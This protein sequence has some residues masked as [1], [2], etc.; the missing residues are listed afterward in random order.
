[1]NRNIFIGASAVVIILVVGYFVLNQKPKEA[2]GAPIT[3]GVATLLT[4]DFAVLGE[5]IVQTARLAADEVNKNGGINGRPLELVIEDSKLDSRSGVAAMQKLV[6]ADGIRYIIGGMSS[7]GSVAAAPI[8]NA[9]HAVDLTPVTG[10][11]NVDEAGDYIFRIANSDVLAGRDLANAML[12]MGYKNVGVVGAVTEYTIDIQK[13]FEKTITD[14]GGTIVVSEQFQPGTTDYRT[15]IAKVRAKNP[16]AVLVLS[17]LGTD[18]AYFVKQ[19]REVGYN[20][21]LFTDF[22]FATNGNVKQIL[23]SLDGIYFTDPAYDANNAKTKAFFALY[24]ATYKTDPAIP[25]HAASTYD[26]VMMLAEALR[27]EG[28]D[29]AKVQQYLSTNIKNYHGLMG[30]YSLDAQGNS[31][32]GFTVRVIKNGVPTDIQ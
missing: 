12:K 2:N 20:P 16:Q 30:T 26:G 13:T 31:D 8:A 14:Q 5:N 17:Q 10:G 11:K 9:A 21:P 29:S 6:N 25:F 7:N 3:V 32:L 24:K 23:G 28:D 4:G 18:A 15:M 22:T 19:S 27:A 1:M